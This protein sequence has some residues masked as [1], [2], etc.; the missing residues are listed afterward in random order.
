MR[1][2]RWPQAGWAIPCV[3]VYC[4]LGKKKSSNSLVAGFCNLGKGK[5]ANLGSNISLLEPRA[6]EGLVFGLLANRPGP[7]TVLGLLQGLWCA[8]CKG[9][10]KTAD[11]AD[12]ERRDRD[13]ARGATQA[14]DTLT[15]HGV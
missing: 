8:V 14:G 9:G 11:S 6:N 10:G 4:I 3:G 12:D 1:S 15:E 2:D 7:V 13:G 5:Q